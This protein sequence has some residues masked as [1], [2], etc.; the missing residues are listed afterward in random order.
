MTLTNREQKMYEDVQAW[1][2]KLYL[3]ES[4]DLAVLYEKTIQNGFALLPDHIKEECSQVLDNM[5]FHLHAII[6]GSQMQIDSRERILSSARI[7]DENVEVIS[8]LKYLKVDQLKYIAQQ[9]IGRHRLYS[10]SQGAIT[11]MGG[12]LSVASDLPAITFINLRLV[13]LI[14]MSYGYEVNTPK[15]MMISL[16]VFHAGTLPKRL[17]KFKLDEL[18]ES[19][20]ET[21][22]LYF[23]N[24]E[25]AIVNYT[26]FE[27]PLKQIM[28]YIAISAFK[29]KKVQGL[30]IV[31][32]CI[33]AGS[34]Y[35]L[36]REVSEFAHHFYQ[37]RYFK[38]RSE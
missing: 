16:K 31:S 21:D 27:Q 19:L 33:G 23:Y 24:G 22:H 38:E 26:W 7:F 8:D 9:Q 20:M 11:G 29:K 35:M 17:Q 3:Y 13:Q 36:T 18:K 10:F 34:N 5:L 1:E 15:E 30:P 25:E 6:Q 37:Y 14:A 4:T 2:K 32:M 12:A 28:K